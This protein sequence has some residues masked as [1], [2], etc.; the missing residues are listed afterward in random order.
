MDAVPENYRP[1]PWVAVFTKT[2]LQW[3]AERLDASNRE[4]RIVNRKLA[5]HRR[6]EHEN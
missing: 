3:L 4:L 6:K 1:A 5:E 2:E